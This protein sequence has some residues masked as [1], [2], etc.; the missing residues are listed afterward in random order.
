[1]KLASLI[2]DCALRHPDREVMVCGNRRI[3]FGELNSNTNRLADAYVARGMKPGDRIA[4][5]LP[6]SAELIEAIREVWETLTDTERWIYHMLVDVGLSMR[7][8]ALALG[9]PKTTFARRRD[10]LAQKLKNELLRHQAVIDHLAK[11]HPDL[12]RMSDTDPET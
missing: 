11:G 1:M 8:V 3:S 9:T 5:Y 6:N 4:M 7:F 10:A 2:D 12:Q